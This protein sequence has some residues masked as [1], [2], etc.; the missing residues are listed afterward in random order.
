MTFVLIFFKREGLDM[1]LFSQKW[2]RDT[3]RDILASLLHEN[4]KNDKS[5]LCAKF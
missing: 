4:I 2:A 5:F 1:L 3:S